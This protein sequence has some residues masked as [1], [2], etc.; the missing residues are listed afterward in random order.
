MLS[1]LT[2]RN[3]DTGRIAPFFIVFS[4]ILII[5]A[6]FIPIVAVM[7]IQ[8]VLF[9]SRDHWIFIRPTA[10]YVV[11]GAGMVWMAVVLLSTLFTKMWADRVEKPYRLTFLHM[12][13]FLLAIPV[14]AYA[15]MHYTYLDD[16]GAHTNLLLSSEEKTIA[17]D[18]VTEVYREVDPETN[19]ILSYTF[20]DGESDIYIPF[21]LTDTELRSHVRQVVNSYELDV[22]EIEAAG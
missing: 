16:H 8:D 17:W 4:F 14:Y 15:V 18:D 1:K 19:R 2:L 10:A 22:T 12:V 20:S 6:V 9:F 3:A 11:F 13:L 21:R 5:S 7:I